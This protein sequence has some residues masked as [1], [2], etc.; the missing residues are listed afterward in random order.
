MAKKKSKPLLDPVKFGLA[1][2]ILWGAIMLLMTLIASSNG[3]G[4][5]FLELFVSI[6]PGFTITFGGAVLGLIYGFIDMFVG[7]YIF[8]WLYN[9]LTK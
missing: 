8:V 6:Y 1:G 5:A 3:F 4:T 2:G 9:W 7:L